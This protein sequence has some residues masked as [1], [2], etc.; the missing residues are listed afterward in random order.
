MAGLVIAVSNN[1][2]SLREAC[3]D[4]LFANANAE[5]DR[6]G[7]TAL[8]EYILAHE[9][10]TLGSKFVEAFI[11]RSCHKQSNGHYVAALECILSIKK[12][13]KILDQLKWYFFEHMTNKAMMWAK[14]HFTG[15]DCPNATELFYRM[16]RYREDGFYPSLSTQKK[17]KITVTL[18]DQLYRTELLSTRM[19]W[20][21]LSNPPPFSCEWLDITSSVSITDTDLQAM[22]TT[23]GKDLGRLSITQCPLITS[24]ASFAFKN[25][26]NLEIK[27]CDLTDKGLTLLSSTCKDTLRYLDVSNNRRLTTFEGVAISKLERVDASGTGLTF[28][29]LEALSKLSRETVKE[30]ILIDT[31]VCYTH[32]AQVLELFDPST[33][34]VFTQQYR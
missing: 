31:P 15:R 13:S 32:R 3:A 26:V 14:L 16:Q 9:D 12:E 2:P 28:M 27:A 7:Y 19:K 5:D 18:S 8:L 30:I 17:R 10:S 11:G 1:I 21:G 25:L 22:C 6:E 34:L 23:F 4:F 33:K 20:R 24:V 29:G